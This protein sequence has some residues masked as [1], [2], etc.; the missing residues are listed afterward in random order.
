MGPVALTTLLSP[1]CLPS[2][3]GT[4]VLQPW[5]PLAFFCAAE[6]KHFPKPSLAAIPVLQALPQTKKIKQKEKDP[7]GKHEIKP[8]IRG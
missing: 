2:P 8:A 3:K 1:L 5:G 4:P 6:T 7:R